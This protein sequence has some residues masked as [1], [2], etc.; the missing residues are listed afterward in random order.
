MDDIAAAFESQGIN[1]TIVTVEIGDYDHPYFEPFRHMFIPARGTKY[2][3]KRLRMRHLFDRGIY[4]PI[5]C[6]EEDAL[7]F[8]YIRK[9]ATVSRVG[10]YHVFDTFVPYFNKVTIPNAEIACL[11][12]AGDFITRTLHYLEKKSDDLALLRVIVDINTSHISTPQRR[13]GGIDSILSQTASFVTTLRETNPAQIAKFILRPFDFALASSIRDF[14]LRRF[15]N[16]PRES[17]VLIYAGRPTKNVESLVEVLAQVRKKNTAPVFLI[18]VGT[19]NYD[20]SK[21]NN[22]ETQKEF[23]ISIDFLERKELFEYIK[24]ADIFVYP[25]LVDGH[26]K[27]VNESQAIGTPVVAF[28][29]AASAVEEIIIHNETGILVPQSDNKR[30]AEEVDALLNDSERRV[31]LANKAKEFAN[32]HYSNESFVRGFLDSANNIS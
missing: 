3:V 30:F 6:L 26:P 22:Y 25:G 8:N 11:Y 23:I 29:S 16:L 9:Q 1:V 2:P 20:I 10:F 17:H 21:W 5:V 31:S 18:L 7:V 12:Y 32:S 14:D 28:A 24:G 4:N 15:F 19:Q 27:I 13:I